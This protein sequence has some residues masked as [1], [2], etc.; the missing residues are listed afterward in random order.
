VT[1]TEVPPATRPLRG[2]VNVPTDKAIS[3]RAALFGALARGTTTVRGY[4]P[5][6]DCAS[7][8]AAIR[9]LGARVL[10]DGN[11]VRIEGWGASGPAGA[12][13]PVDCGRSATTMR[14]LCGALAPFPIDVALTGDPQ[15][16][17]RPMERVAAPLRSMGA[18]VATAD[19]GRPPVELRGGGLRGI[20]YAMP[21][22]SAQVKSAV[23][24]A[25]LGASGLTTVREPVPTRDH[26]E[27][28]L[29]AMGARLTTD[30]RGTGR[31]VA[32]EPG[33]LAAVEITVPGDVSSAAPLVA[34]A[35]LVPGSDLTIAGVGLNPT[36]AGLLGVLSG[37]GASIETE[38]TPDVGGEP[39]G[40]VRVR[41]AP[42]HAASVG[43]SDV[44]AMVDELPLLGLLATQA[45]GVSQ[46]R[47]AD[48]LR[49]KESDRIAV[50]V[51]GL[52]ALGADVEEL[53]DGFVVAG[54]TP[55]TGGDLDSAGDHRMAMVFAVAALIAHGPVRVRGM[56]SVGDSFPGFLAA[57]QGL[58]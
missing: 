31:S 4:S 41:H 24:L 48:E 9:S 35:A 28:L 8:L 3:H 44:P 23:L 57:L 32:V 37:M 58:R 13:A 6:G 50:L 27:R 39:R 33:S 15:L 46:V 49:V 18:R 56:E 40:D 21:V 12:H 36:R 5:A 29:A 17:A 1:A 43:A 7:T 54:P 2:R 53:P 47:G 11:E 38:G 42:L 55:L 22:A 34:A 52:R 25:G 26:T 30:E 16:L 45:E 51:A 10:S 14:L 20:D 19:G